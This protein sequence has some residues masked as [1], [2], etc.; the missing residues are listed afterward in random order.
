[1]THV[2]AIPLSIARNIQGIPLN[3]DGNIRTEIK[4][5]FHFSFEGG[6]QAQCSHL[7]SNNSAV[8]FG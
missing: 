5:S 2:Q 4:W 7:D 8:V 6:I 1:M 3:N